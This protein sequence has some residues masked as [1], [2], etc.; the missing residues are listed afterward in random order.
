M[1]K[2][3]YVSMS[4]PAPVQQVKSLRKLTRV[5]VIMI[6]HNSGSSQAV[7]SGVPRHSAQTDAMGPSGGCVVQERSALNEEAGNTLFTESNAESSQGSCTW[8]RAEQERGCSGKLTASHP[9][10]FQQPRQQKLSSVAF[11]GRTGEQ[12]CVATKAAP[13]PLK[14]SI[15]LQSQSMLHSCTYGSSAALMCV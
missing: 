10:P 6:W 8:H 5:R 7:L 13:T 9:P 11:T 3:V 2:L 14:L 15:E 1:D 4:S 12:M